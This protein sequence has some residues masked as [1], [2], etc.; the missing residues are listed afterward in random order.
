MGNESGRQFIRNLTV[1][2]LLDRWPKVMWVFLDY[3][4]ACIGC[5]MASF[6]TVEDVARN[7]HMPVE[8]LVDRIEAS[9]TEKSAAEE[10]R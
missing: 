8:E 6:D 4:M 1:K 2:Q 7:Y 5:D 9:I 3:K 10:E